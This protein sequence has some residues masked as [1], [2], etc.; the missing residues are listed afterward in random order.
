MTERATLG[1]KTKAWA[2]VALLTLAPRVALAEEEGARPEARPT[3]GTTTPGGVRIDAAYGKGIT[4]GSSNGDTELNIRARVQVQGAVEENVPDAKGERAPVDTSFLI[5]RMRLLFQGYVLER[6]VRYYFQLGFSTRDMEPDL[7]VPVRDAFVEWLD[8]RDASVRAGQMKVPFSRE[9]MISS[10]ALELVDRSNVNAEMSLDR[11]VGVQ[12]FSRDL[13]GAGGHLRYNAGVFGGDGRN[14]IADRAGLLWAARVEMLPFGDFDDYVEA[15]LEHSH[16]PAL[17][18]GFA[19]A[20]NQSTNRVR[21]TVTESY[22]TGTVDYR[23]AV[24]DM[25]FKWRG[26]SVLGELHYRKA[27]RPIVGEKVDASG[28]TVVER[29]RSAVGYLVQV[30]APLAKHWDLAL[31]YGEVRPLDGDVVH[32]DRE[33]GGGIGF[34]PKGHNLKIQLDY[35]HLIRD[36]PTVDDVE[37]NRVRLQTQL[38]F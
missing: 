30:G 1:G 12:L 27:D 28:K 4:V 8:V 6:R 7:L 20:Y 32:R 33:I 31:R 38:F 5:R 3:T 37:T 26:F 23:H 15:D 24:A 36:T 22:T 10:S 21:S 17:S 2:L 11:D 14:R 19:T 9:R 34:F 35:F 25:H 16:K 13:L 29:G 18:V